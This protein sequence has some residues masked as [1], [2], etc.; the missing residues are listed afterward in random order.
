MDVL[1]LTT[2]EENDKVT[3]T[4][5]ERHQEKPRNDL[6]ASWVV[7]VFEFL[8]NVLACLNGAKNDS[9]LV[10]LIYGVT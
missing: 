9:Q 6:E 7:K 8:D 3:T 5:R 10:I 4:L 2:S 1:D